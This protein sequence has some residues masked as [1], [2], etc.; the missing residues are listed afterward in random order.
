MNSEII[1]NKLGD[2]SEIY[3]IIRNFY[4]KELKK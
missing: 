3:D 2:E 1:K 4:I